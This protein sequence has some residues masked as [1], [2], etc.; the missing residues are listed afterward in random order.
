MHSGDASRAGTPQA[1]NNRT[2]ALKGLNNV[3]LELF[4][5]QLF[6][7]K[8]RYTEMFLVIS[9]ANGH[10]LFNFASG[11]LAPCWP[12]LS[13]YFHWNSSYKYQ[14]HRQVIWHPWLN[15]THQATWHRPVEESSRL[16]LM[17]GPTTWTV[18]VTT[19]LLA[20]WSGISPSL[21]PSTYQKP[22]PH[23][24]YKYIWITSNNE[25]S[26][27]PATTWLGDGETPFQTKTRET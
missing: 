12:S 15:T 2:H 4:P 13:K 23:I 17:L 9:S 1:A 7:I 21:Y 5:W 18:D 24:P 11:P 25:L 16:P 26:S 22:F 8:N 27:A 14:H 6:S 19:W 10:A 20:D 3:P